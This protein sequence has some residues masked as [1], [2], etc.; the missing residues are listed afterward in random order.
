MFIGRGRGGEPR[1]SRTG[2]QLAYR[3]CLF[4]R[5][6]AM[7]LKIVVSARSRARTTPYLYRTYLVTAAEDEVFA[8]ALCS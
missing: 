2:F 4:S 3:E 6:Y 1:H 7:S 8:A 5:I